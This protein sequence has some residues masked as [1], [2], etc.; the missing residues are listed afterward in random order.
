MVER[1]YKYGAI[2][3]SSPDGVQRAE[4]TFSSATVWFSS[5][6]SMNDP[7][8][9]QSKFTFN[10]TADQIVVLL[11][12]EFR[13]REDITL[14]D[15]LARA[16]GIYASGVYKDQKY[17]GRFAD[18]V[19]EAMKT[20]IGMYCM[21]E[22]NSNILMW[23]HY[24][25][26]HTGYCLEFEATSHTPVFGKAQKVNYSEN[27]PAIDYFNTPSEKQVDLLFLTKYIDWIYEKEW[28]IIDHLSGPGLKDYPIE[29]LKS[30]TFGMR[31]TE[32]NKRLIREWIARR[33]NQIA[34]YQAVQDRNWY[35]VTAH[36]I[37]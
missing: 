36:A 30:V 13:K 19:A 2:D 26:D 4:R 14:L 20:E 5:P 17:Y 8:E 25:K 35:G 34:L 27:Y 16:H 37:D 7:F 23:S 24:A 33:G 31:M 10:G 15:A 28:R 12:R 21:S 1:L 18:D 22:T 9:C 3:H 11:V 29:L 6:A 32:Q